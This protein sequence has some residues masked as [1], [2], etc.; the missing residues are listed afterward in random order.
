MSNN[1][2]TKKDQFTKQLAE[3]GIEIDKGDKILSSIA[4]NKLS[5]AMLSDIDGALAG[6]SHSAHSNF[7]KGK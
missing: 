3:K 2:N 1:T 7:S 5:E 4:T 6:C